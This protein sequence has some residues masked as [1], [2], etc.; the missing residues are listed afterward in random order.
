MIFDRV[1]EGEV[2][3]ARD[4][5]F[6]ASGKSINVARGLHVLG[7]KAIACTPLGGEAG[8]ILLADLKKSGIAHRVVKTF[9]QTRTCVTVIDRARQDATEL[10]EEAGK[11]RAGEIAAM[12]A[13][14]LK[15]LRGAE[16]VILSGSLAAGVKKDF[17][18]R[19]CAE[20]HAAGAKVILDA[21]G[22]E[23]MRALECRPLV[24]KP[25][26]TESGVTLGKDLGNI[27][28]LKW[29]MRQL[30]ERG[31]QW[32]IVTMGKAGA[33]VCDGRNFWEIASLKVKAVSAIGSG[34][35]FA[36][37]LSCAIKRGREIPEACK[38]A[39]ACAAANTLVPGS[40]KFLVEDVRK[41]ERLVKIREV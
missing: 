29:A 5:F 39:T 20:A 38:L 27:S 35:A 9:A 37:G 40:G 14:F 2:N 23:M 4:V 16:M 22:E 34:D 36:A 30:C 17:Y 13:V 18:A 26:R 15:S 31:A 12:R 6:H 11:M 7:E 24:V 41:L 19:C 33:M 25:N 3:R 28:E 8:K 1:R 10:V 21:R 32:A